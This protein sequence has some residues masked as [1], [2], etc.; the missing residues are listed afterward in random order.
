M[1]ILTTSLLEGPPLMGF[2]WDPFDPENPECEER[3]VVKPPGVKGNA[4]VLNSWLDFRFFHWIIWRRERVG[5][6]GVRGYAD[7]CVELHYGLGQHH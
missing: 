7:V 6:A 4:F 3:V 5:P 2:F 1:C